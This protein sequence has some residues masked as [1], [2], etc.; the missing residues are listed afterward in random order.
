MDDDPVSREFDLTPGG[1]AVIITVI[2]LACLAFYAVIHGIEALAWCTC[3][4][5]H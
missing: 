4:L 3:G 2:G 1:A 5:R